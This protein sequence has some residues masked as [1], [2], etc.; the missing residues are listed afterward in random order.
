MRG[1]FRVM[2]VP[3]T[4][5]VMT[6]ARPPAL[7][8]ASP[9]TGSANAPVDEKAPLPIRTPQSAVLANS[10]ARHVDGGIPMSVEGCIWL[11]PRVIAG[12]P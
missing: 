3:A 12:S 2:S 11:A 8:S 6:G 4:L 9:P 7:T 10:R 1:A 5:D